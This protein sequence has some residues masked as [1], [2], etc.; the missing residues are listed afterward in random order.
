MNSKVKDLIVALLVTVLL[1]LLLMLSMFME[2]L[3]AIRDIL[4]DV[5]QSLSVLPR[6][7]LNSLIAECSAFKR[8]WKAILCRKEK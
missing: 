4:H 7:I 2:I 3:I 5:W 1:P 8:I 6:D